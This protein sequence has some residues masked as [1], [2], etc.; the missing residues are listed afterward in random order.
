MYGDRYISLAPLSLPSVR[1]RVESFLAA[2][3]LRLDDVDCYATITR[4]EDSDEILAGGGLK[5]NV[6]KCIAV[7]PELRSEGLSGSLVSYL[8]G[9]AHERGCDTVK[10]FTKPENTAIFSSMGFVTLAAC[11]KAVLMEDGNGLRRYERYLASLRKEGRNGAIVMNANP[12]TRGHRYL[13][14]SAASQV[15]NLYVIAVKEDLSRLPYAE[16]LA[17]IKAGTADIPNV[18][19]CEGSDYAISAATFPTYFLKKLSDASDTQMSLDIDLFAKHIAPALGV[20]VRFAGSEPADPLTARYNELMSELLP[21]AGVEFMEISRLEDGERPVSATLLRKALDRGSLSEAMKFAYRSTLPYLVADLAEA[22]LRQELDTTPKPGLVDRNNSGAHSDMDYDSMSA[23]I[24]ALRPWF[25]RMAVDAA[26]GL[27]PAKIKE[28]GIEA[29]KSMLEA[30]GGVNSHKGALF[31]VGLTVAAASFLAA[32]EGGVT[33][34][35]LRPLLTQ[36]AS[37]IAAANGTHGAGVISKYRVKGALE[38]AREAYPELFSEWLP[39]YR[40]LEGDR[41]RNHKTLLKIMTVLDDTNVLHRGGGEALAR[42]KR[43]AAA[44]LGDFSE[45]RLA[46]LDRQYISANI[47]PGGSADMLSLTIFISTIINN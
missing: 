12:F 45:S 34:R 17:M 18:T 43:D 7:S 32:T 41:Y 47:S 33:E 6:I 13:V 14:E 4:S 35:K 42:V 22:A 21:G 46:E 26:R 30:T 23:G 16:R 10:V 3:S 27:D 20:S 29:E 1:A 19:V 8:V 31:C 39:W 38:S 37:G 44:L 36:A 28:A 11:D 40:S 15:D 2:N 5:G 9:L 25:V 24:R